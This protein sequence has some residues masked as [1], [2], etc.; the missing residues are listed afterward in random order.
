ME[1]THAELDLA[2]ED[3]ESLEAPFGWGDFWAGVGAGLAVAGL[4]AA[5]LALT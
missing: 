1:T 3:L 2:I 4:Y 5:G